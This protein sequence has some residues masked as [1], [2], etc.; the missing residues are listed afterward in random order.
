MS[1]KSPLSL[2]SPFGAL[3]SSYQLD[4]ASDGDLNGPGQARP[5][6]RALYEN[7]LAASLGDLRRRQREADGAFLQQGI[8]FTVYGEKGGTERVFPFDLL[9]RILTAAEWDA[10]PGPDAAHARVESVPP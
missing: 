7:L 4:A 1:P 2:P 5:H 10:Q 3:F 9:P 8:T 6:C